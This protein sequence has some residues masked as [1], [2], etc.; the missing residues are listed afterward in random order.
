MVVILSRDNSISTSLLLLF[1]NL[2]DTSGIEKKEETGKK[3]QF[4]KPA[5][6]FDFSNF[7]MCLFN[8]QNT[9]HFLLLSLALGIKIYFKLGH[10]AS[11]WHCI[12][13]TPLNIYPVSTWAGWL[14]CQE[15]EP[16]RWAGP[17]TLLFLLWTRTAFF[18][19]KIRMYGLTNTSPLDFNS[20]F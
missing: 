3:K 2:S 19:I 4:W 11:P 17:S 7:V 6:L 13:A 14:S 10:F 12:N 20:C 5:G 15:L 18:K 8:S 16:H 1:T 9:L